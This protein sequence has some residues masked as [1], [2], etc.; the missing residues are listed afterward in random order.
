MTLVPCKISKIKEHRSPY[1]DRYTRQK[2]LEEFAASNV[3]CVEV[4]NYVHSSASSCAC[5][6]NTT[7][8]ANGMTGIKALERGNHV[9]LVKTAALSKLK[10]ASRK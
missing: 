9:Y 4:L 1:D 2:L 7:I 8:R 6:L 3:A 10:K 5:S